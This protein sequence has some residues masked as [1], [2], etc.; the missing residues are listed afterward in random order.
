MGWLLV[1][2]RNVHVAGDGRR[3]VRDR[4]VGAEASR[5][6]GGGE[7]DVWLEPEEGRWNW[8]GEVGSWVD[9]DGEVFLGGVGGWEA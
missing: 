1:Q 4:G 5:G 3:E 6:E 8:G 7:R 2:K 9:E